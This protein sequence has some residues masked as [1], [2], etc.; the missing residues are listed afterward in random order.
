MSGRLALFLRLDRLFDI[1]HPI[2]SSEIIQAY[3]RLATESSPNWHDSVDLC[4][5]SKLQNR[6]LLD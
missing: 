3:I 4:N 5:K 2:D 1:L 6:C